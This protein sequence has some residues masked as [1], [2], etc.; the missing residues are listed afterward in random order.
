[1]AAALGMSATEEPQMSEHRT[2]FLNILVVDDEVNI[3]KTLSY[4][5]AAEGHTVI[6]VS[7]PA[8]AVQEARMRSFDMAFVDLK[9]GSEDGMD[10]L[11]LLRADS[12][13][14]KIAIITAHASIESAV[15]AIRRGAADYLEKPFTPD[16]VKLL[17]RRIAQV[18]ELENEINSLKEDIHRLAPE[19]RLQS[20]N[21][22]MQR[23]IEMAKKAAASEAIILLRGESGTG[24]SA[25]ARTIHSGSLRAAKPMAVVACPA[26]PPDLL[27]S[28][29]FGHA[30]GAFTGAVRD[31]P[32]RIASC[33]GGTLLLDEI[34]DMAP[35]VQAK[36]LRFV[37]DREY[38][39]LGESTPRKAN[40]RIIAATN[41]DLDQRVAD[42]LFR[43]DLF[44]RLNV[45]SIT[46]PPL[47]DRPE[48][49]MPLAEEFL[50]HFCRTN[51]KSIIGFTD[52]AAEAV[53]GYA[54]P[55]NIRELRNTIERAVILGCGSKL[56][57]G[58]LPENI[59]PTAG[60]P[61]LGDLVPLSVIEELH[62]R[63][64]IAHTSS[65]QQAAEVLG[66]D[67]ATLWRRRKS[68]GI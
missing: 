62:I 64:V 4:C 42:G 8:D 18:R 58:D 14:I 16:Q 35:S 24:K 19:A 26:M 21:V 57:K 32:G 13:W 33:E 59:T 27:E 65:L 1:M 52:D 6:A 7:N 63:R 39:R 48:D 50:L 12:P 53:T 30:R 23:V 10:L 49:I 46:L 25:L 61:R 29:L 2:T 66:M 20:R 31:N 37:Q 67:Q 5:L 40:V 9:L 60:L 11:P 54:W 28:E 51:H 3:R 17:T 34:A 38:E 68:Y 45:I 44:Y 43:E 41:A 55:G 56:A 47:R 36:L 22:G 15:E